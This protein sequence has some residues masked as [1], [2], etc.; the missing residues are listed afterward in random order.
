M[1]RFPNTALALKAYDAVDH[2]REELYRKAKS[3]TSFGKWSRRVAADV[4]AVQLAFWNDTSRSNSR[5]NCLRTPVG[6]I[7][8]LVRSMGP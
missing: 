4:K 7:R 5:E 6:V 1:K 2:E 3:P 8:A